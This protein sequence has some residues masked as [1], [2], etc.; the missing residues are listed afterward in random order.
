MKNQCHIFK[1][2]YN[3]KPGTIFLFALLFFY[4]FLPP[5]LILIGC[6]SCYQRLR[7]TVNL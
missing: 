3:V 7:S 2:I 5:S 4:D 1:S 6:W